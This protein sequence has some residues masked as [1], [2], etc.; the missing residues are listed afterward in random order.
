MREETLLH[1]RNEYDIK[2]QPFGGMHSHES[3]RFLF[4]FEFILITLES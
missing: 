2:F 1:S 4:F 3:H